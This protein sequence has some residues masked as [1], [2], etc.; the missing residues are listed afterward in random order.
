M[1]VLY[2][3]LGHLTFEGVRLNLDVSMYHWF[4]VGGGLFS[5][6]YKYGIFRRKTTQSNF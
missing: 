5:L 1:V 4:L 3:T 2:V 6:S